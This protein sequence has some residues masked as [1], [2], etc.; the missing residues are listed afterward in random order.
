MA[1][2]AKIIVFGG[3]ILYFVLQGTNK[4]KG[5]ALVQNVALAITIKLL[6]LSYVWL[7]QVKPWKNLF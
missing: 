5:R 3:I 4:T 6:K 1:L 7:G 2:K